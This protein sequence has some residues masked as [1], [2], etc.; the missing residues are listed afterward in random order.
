V[1]VLFIAPGNSVH[2]AR[3][4][5]QCQSRGIRAFLYS[6]SDFSQVSSNHDLTLVNAVVSSENEDTVLSR[7]LFKHI[8]SNKLNE[9]FKI[10]RHLSEIR[11][12]VKN[13]NIDLVHIHW[14]FHSAAFAATFLPGLKIVATPWGSDVQWSLKG[15][16]YS[17][18]Q[19]FIRKVMVSRVIRRS[20]RFSCDAIHLKNRLVSLGA[21]PEDVEIIYFGVDVNVFAKKNFSEEYRSSIGLKPDD[22]MVLSN[23]GLEP[24][25]DVETFI[26]AAAISVQRDSRLMFCV[27]SSGSQREALENLVDELGISERV[28]FLGRLTNEE[29][30]VVTASAD[31]YVST[32]TSDGG[33]AASVAEA[34]ASAVPVLNTD[35]GENSMWLE[36]SSAGY[37]F[38]VGDHFKLADLILELASDSLKR[39]TLGEKGRSIILN[40]NNSILESKKI[41]DLYQTTTGGE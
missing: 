14:L 35:F 8:T 21:S 9:M 3:W 20:A 6:T 27:A 38:P 40:K 22:L 1:K 30:P 10:L 7:N 37:T 17:T 4:I 41:F 26:R 39:S 29:F 32:S 33:L 23:R 16:N 18:R 11:R 5:L 19:R 24:V 34:M 13:Y 2:T 25:Y 15:S 31:I 12:A 36:G 28:K